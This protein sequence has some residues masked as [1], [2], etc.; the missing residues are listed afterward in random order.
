MGVINVIML[1]LHPGLVASLEAPSNH[2]IVVSQE[3][4]LSS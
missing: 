4:R 3:E 1:A 2:R